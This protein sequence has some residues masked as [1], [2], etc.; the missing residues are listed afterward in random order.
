VGALAYAGDKASSDPALL[1]PSMLTSRVRLWGE[2]GRRETLSRYFRQNTR[3]LLESAAAA[4][5]Q[6]CASGLPQSKAWTVL[7]EASPA[8]N[9]FIV[10]WMEQ[11]SND[12]FRVAHFKRLFEAATEIWC[13]SYSDCLKLEFLAGRR[14]VYM[15]LY[16]TLPSEYILRSTTPS[17][18]NVFQHKSWL[19]VQLGRSQLPAPPR[20]SA[21]PLTS[22]AD[23]QARCSDV[24]FDEQGSDG[25]V[26]TSEERSSRQTHHL[27]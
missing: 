2:C 20:V 26:C 21:V 6:G 13:F 17:R 9:P 15:P 22:F 5:A 14:A 18:Q 8:V 24:W 12:A 25:A 11:L 3:G 1:T 7:F 23:S 16:T 10:F 4:R 27:H 19:N